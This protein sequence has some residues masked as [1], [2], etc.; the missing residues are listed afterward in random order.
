MMQ[1]L[2][3][4]KQISLYSYYMCK[5][6]WDCPKIIR[7]HR[8]V[9]SVP[10]WLVALVAQSPDPAASSSSLRFASSAHW[11][12][13]THSPIGGEGRGQGHERGGMVKQIV[14]LPVHHFWFQQARRLVCTEPSNAPAVPPGSKWSYENRAGQVGGAWYLSSVFFQ[15]LLS[16]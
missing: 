1:A 16:I 2:I 4:Y 13:T 9:T 12:K 3:M 6:D 14:C 7:S 11:P 15:L 8:S 5:C 10:L